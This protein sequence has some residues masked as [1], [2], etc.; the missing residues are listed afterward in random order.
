MP[1]HRALSRAA[2]AC[3]LA[4]GV[5]LPTTAVAEEGGFATVALDPNVKA[6]IDAGVTWAPPSPPPQLQQQD[7]EMINFT[8]GA[9]ALRMEH[10]LSDQSTTR[11][12]DASSSAFRSAYG[13]ES[14]VR[15]MEYVSNLSYPLNLTVGRLPDGTRAG[16]LRIRLADMRLEVSGACATTKRTCARTAAVTAAIACAFPPPPLP[17]SPSPLP[18]PPPSS[19][20]W[21]DADCYVSL[22]SN[23]FSQIGEGNLT[24][25]RTVDD[26]VKTLTALSEESDEGTASDEGAASEA[27]AP[28]S[29]IDLQIV[30]RPENVWK[31]EVK[32]RLSS[33]GGSEEGKEREG[34]GGEC[35]VVRNMALLAKTMP[36]HLFVVD[37]VCGARTPLEAWEEY[38]GVY[39]KSWDARDYNRTHLTSVGSECAWDRGPDGGPADPRAPS[40]S[41]SNGAAGDASSSAAAG[42][43]SQVLDSHAMA[44]VIL[45]DPPPAHVR[46]DEMPRAA[47]FV[48]RSSV[49]FEV[50][51]DASPS[52]G[53]SS[54]ASLGA[55]GALYSSPLASRVQGAMGRRLQQWDESVWDF[56]EGS[57]PLVAGGSMTPV[58][59][60]TETHYESTL[61]FE[62]V[63]RMQDDQATVEVGAMC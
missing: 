51:L 46:P 44:D 57:E 49:A 53:L 35:G 18:L 50:T 6:A 5:L 30:C 24:S 42:V 52:G 36:L 37:L 9:Y 12:A 25:G 40:S 41:D 17:L 61:G 21:P 39:C 26:L 23:S 58:R 3:V 11:E 10:F 1:P 34:N 13:G 56:Y 28:P 32:L 22:L 2:L 20:L 15:A 19:P 14:V 63:Q 8:S 48:R 55:E 31:H 59:L 16:R 45:D 54:P 47:S 60:I 7:S 27:A 62:R 43:D 4:F 33:G 38:L 29:D